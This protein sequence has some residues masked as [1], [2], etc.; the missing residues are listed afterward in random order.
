MIEVQNLSR[1]YGD[2]AAIADISFSIEQNEIIG[3]LGLNG[4]GK[5]TTLKILGWLTESIRGTSIHQWKQLD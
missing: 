1:Y 3:F 4:A 2:F 5:S